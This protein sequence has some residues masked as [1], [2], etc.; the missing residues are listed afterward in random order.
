MG[1][2]E[3]ER[4]MQRVLD[5]LGIPLKVRWNSNPKTPESGLIDTETGTIFIYDQDEEE[6]WKTL[7]HEILEYKFRTVFSA[8]R[9]LV[10]HLIEVIERLLYEKKEAL[11]DFI[12]QIIK[13]IEKERHVAEESAVELMGKA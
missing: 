1:R 8:Y 7:T 9:Q 6:A 12:P 4:R 2:A 11:L 13:R 3:V 10:N 5:G